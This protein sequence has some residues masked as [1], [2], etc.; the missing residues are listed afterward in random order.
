VWLK[1]LSGLERKMQRTFASDADKVGE[2]VT[3]LGASVASI[4]GG[5]RQWWKDG[6]TRTEWLH[7]WETGPIDSEAVQSY[8][9]WKLW[10]GLG[11][12]SDALIVVI[13]L[14]VI[15]AVLL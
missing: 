7:E 2:F 13:V 5:M 10:R 9:D 15:L 8:R 14:L 4:P 11:I 12:V 6:H 3:D 1:T